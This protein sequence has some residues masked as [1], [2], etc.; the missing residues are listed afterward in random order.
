[1]INYSIPAP[2]RGYGVASQFPWLFW[3]FFFLLRIP[4]TEFYG[5]RTSASP[6]FLPFLLALLFCFC[7]TFLAFVSWLIIALPRGS[8]TH[9]EAGIFGGSAYALLEYSHSHRTSFLK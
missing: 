4:Y 6:L 7:L 2:D 1:M 5:V 9:V 8:A 3:I